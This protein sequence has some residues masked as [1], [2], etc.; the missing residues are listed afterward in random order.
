MP[1]LSKQ[2]QHLHQ[3]TLNRQKNTQL[4]AIHKILSE[5][6]EVTLT[7]I[8]NILS[9]LSKNDRILKVDSKEEHVFQ[10]I[11][12]LQE[13]QKSYALKL[14]DTMRYPKGKIKGD[15]ISIYLQKKALKSIT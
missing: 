10:Q 6:D 12:D 13:P 1:K 7:H 9:K 3:L 11:H 2:R 15:I 5:M 8:Q 4:N 14:F